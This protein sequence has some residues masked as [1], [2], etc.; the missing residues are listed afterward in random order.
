MLLVGNGIKRPQLK[1]VKHW[2]LVGH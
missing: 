2:W 1:R